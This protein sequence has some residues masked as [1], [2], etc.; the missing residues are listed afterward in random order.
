MGCVIQ[1]LSSLVMQHKLTLIEHTFCFTGGLN[2]KARLDDWRVI[3]ALPIIWLIDFMLKT[4][5]IAQPLFDN[6]RTPENVRGVFKNL[7]CNPDQVD[8]ELV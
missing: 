5:F 6:F 7:Y 4:R 1:L 3:V 2:N 8:D